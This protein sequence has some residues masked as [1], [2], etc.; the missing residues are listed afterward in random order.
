MDTIDKLKEFR[1]R[2]INGL[3]IDIEELNSYLDDENIEIKL[4]GFNN[5]TTQYKN[6]IIKMRPYELHQNEFNRSIGKWETQYTIARK[7]DNYYILETDK[8]VIEFTDSQ[9][10]PQYHKTFKSTIKADSDL[11]A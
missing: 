5:N 2:M 8:K 7:T 10:Q 3:E 11:A 6:K 4:Y 1:E 9:K